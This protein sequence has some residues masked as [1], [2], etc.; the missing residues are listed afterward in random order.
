MDTTQ[1][2]TRCSSNLISDI[3]NETV[4]IL[5][6]LDTDIYLR[7]GQRKA[8]ATPEF[9]TCDCDGSYNAAAGPSQ[10]CG[11]TDNTYCGGTGTQTSRRGCCPPAKNATTC[12]FA[13]GDLAPHNRSSA[14]QDPK[15]RISEDRIRRG[16]E[17][18]VKNMAYISALMGVDKMLKNLLKYPL[19]ELRLT[20][21]LRTKKLEPK[22]TTP[23]ARDIRKYMDMIVA[24]EIQCMNN[25]EVYTVD[26]L[27]LGAFAFHV[28]IQGSHWTLT[29]ILLAHLGELD[30]LH[31]HRETLALIY[32]IHLSTSSGYSEPSSSE[33]GDT[34]HGDDAGDDSTFSSP[35]LPQS[36]ENEPSNNS[37]G[38]GFGSEDEND[39]AT[40]KDSLSGKQASSMSPENEQPNDGDY[41]HFIYD[42]EIQAGGD[43][44]PTSANPGS[45]G[46]EDEQST[47]ATLVI[48]DLKIKAMM[49]LARVPRLPIPVFQGSRNSNLRRSKSIT[50]TVI[51]RNMSPMT[52]QEN[53]TM[54]NMCLCTAVTLME[55][56]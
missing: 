46:F 39:A 18:I 3:F 28:Y 31:S 53:T 13:C 55:G 37:D 7:D 6:D 52:P 38:H 40:G 1:P 32:G 4:Q 33:Y 42:D 8:H 35:D 21:T 44:E 10:L 34:S 17:Q 51:P 11:M 50:P 29:H 26:L 5:E 41:H 23:E 48:L 2:Q 20:L 30:I 25:G 24:H 56:A 45:S 49:T 22:G 54:R 27:T 47:M 43:G 14:E 19:R 12:E 15:L 16:H 36:P 9:G